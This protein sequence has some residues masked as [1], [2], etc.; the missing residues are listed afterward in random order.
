V[1]ALRET[2]TLM[3]VLGA[4]L[5]VG[6]LAALV[7]L[8]GVQDG[9]SPGS[10]TQVSNTQVLDMQVAGIASAPSLR[11]Y[12]ESHQVRVTAPPGDFEARLRAS[13]LPDPVVVVP[14]DFEAALARGAVPSI[15]VLSGSPSQRTEADMARV[16]QALDGFVRDRVAADLAARGIDT[17]LLQPLRVSHRSLVPMPTTASIFA[18]LVPF[19]MILAVL[20]GA[21]TAALDTTS[22]E[23][24]RGSLE[25]LLTNPSRH[26]ALV[27]GKWGAVA[28][29]GVLVALL[30]CLS[31]LLTQWAMHSERLRSMLH[32]GWRE[33]V[34]SWLLLMPYAA[35]LPAV[36]MAVATPCRTYK[37]A[38]AK[39][40]LLV[41]LL[42][43]LPVMAIFASGEPTWQLWVPGLAQNTLLGNLFNG[44]ALSATQLLI[45]FAAGLALTAACIGFIATSLRQAATK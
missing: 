45:P 4:A 2:R 32:F 39:S 24:E 13:T 26:G 34:L 25:P 19:L 27:L 31:L 16:Q 36:L 17:R 7:M 33:A 40:N 42:A 9:A 28:A 12:L 30:C 15:E 43:A 11:A 35:A 18:R 20:Y 14:G 6:P 8:T 29:V 23:R 1:D 37:E 3:V 5:L 38:Q 22:G 10:N 41:L 44:E 21:L